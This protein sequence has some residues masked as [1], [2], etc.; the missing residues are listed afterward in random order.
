MSPRQFD[1]YMLDV[2]AGRN[3]KL[4]RLDDSERCAFFLGILAIAAKSPIRGRLL[5]GDIH[6][7]PRDV[8]L[9][10]SVKERSAKSAMEKLRTIGVLLA[11]EE[12]GCERV[13]DFEEWNPPPKTDAT[14]AERQARRRAR[15]ADHAESN[16]TNTVTS[17]RDGRDGHGVTPVII[18][19]TEVEVEVEVEEKEPNGSSS[20]I[21]KATTDTMRLS[22]L[23]AD[24]II[25]RDPKAKVAPESSRWLAAT[26]LLIADRHGDVDEVERVLRWSQADPFWQSNILSPGKLR[27]KFTQL[28]GKM[29]R[30]PADPRA[31]PT[32][33]A[34]RA[35]QWAAEDAA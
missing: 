35:K 23:L 2:E 3:L 19:P 31:A 5:I 16:G 33:W 1:R 25:Q 6:A 4:S 22:H 18:T 7:E 20:E 15:L 9:Q 30:A 11:D 24:L 8:S 26:R 17:R 32:R 12:Y 21:A 13:H 10:A 14:A 27:E 34:D 28:A 29:N